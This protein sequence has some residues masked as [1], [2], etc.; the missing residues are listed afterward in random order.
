MSDTFFTISPHWTLYIVPYFFV[1]GIAGGAYFL[2][3]L[4]E[5]FGEPE[6]RP[7]IR[8]GYY[9]AAV[10]A[11]ISGLLLTIDLGRP[12][13]FWHMLFQSHD[14]PGIML[15]TWSPMSIGAWG[16]VVF[17]AFAFVSALGALA[18]EGRLHWRP[19]YALQNRT[20][21]RVIAVFGGAFAF[22]L[23]GYTGVLLSV[24]NRPIWADSN[25][26]GLLFLI[27]GASTAAA[28]LILIGRRRGAH[29]NSIGWLIRF[30][31]ALLILELV[32]LLIFL[33]SLGAVARV[34]L[35]AW[36]ALLLV[37]VV[38][39]GIVV[40]LA[41]H[42]RPGRLGRWGEQPVLTAAVLVLIGGF[43]LRVVILL[44]SDSIGPQRLT[45][46]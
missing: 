38:A 8:L 11:I 1:G 3:A 18:E 4:L 40:P 36:G 28:T 29:A 27:S 45:G 2:A 33:V 24:T 26:V 16:L 32:V 15:K 23:A 25:F 13:R 46:I 14:F 17:S 5:W 42:W 9:V 37:G 12:L 10:G 6:D 7:V 39:L 44:A 43:L 21:A 22:F 35:S 34:W 31:A 30:D 19:L 20:T 41:L